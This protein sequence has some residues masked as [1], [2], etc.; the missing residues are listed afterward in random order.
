MTFKGASSES[1]AQQWAIVFLRNCFVIGS[2]I[3]ARDCE[4]KP[5]NEAR[6]VRHQRG[7]L[8]CDWQVGC[9]ARVAFQVASPYS[10]MWTVPAMSL[11]CTIPFKVHGTMFPGAP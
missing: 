9:Q 4:G 7:G 8:P 6:F 2:P 10:P 5:S 3:Y 11:P 1:A